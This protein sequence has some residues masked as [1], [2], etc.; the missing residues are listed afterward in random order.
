L[1]RFVLSATVALALAACGSNSSSTRPPVTEA[2]TV[3]TTT[4]P[5][6]PPTSQPAATSTSTRPPPTQAVHPTTTVRPASGT[7]A[8]K[9]PPSGSKTTVRVGQTLTVSLSSTYWVFG[10]SSDPAV[11]KD[12]GGQVT[13][14]PRGTC[15]P[16]GGCGT[17]SESFKAIAPG[18]AEVTASRTSCGEAMRCTGDAGSFKLEVTVSS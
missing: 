14:A 16:G 6:E 18:Q 3:P 5:T 7:V 12:I 10:G 9:D 15:V 8:L 1:R 4:P 17:S 13:P 11:L 2:T